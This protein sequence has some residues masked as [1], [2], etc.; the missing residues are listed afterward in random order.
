MNNWLGPFKTADDAI[1][2]LRRSVAEIIGADPNTWPDHKNAPLAIS[3]VVG[4]RAGAIKQLRKERDDVAQQLVQSEIGKREI[5]EAH[6]AMQIE[7]GKLKDLEV[8]RCVKINGYIVDNARLAE[9]VERLRAK[10][11]RMERQEP[12]GYGV[13]YVEA[14]N[15]EEDWD[16][17]WK[18]RVFAEDHVKD[19]VQAYSDLGESIGAIT[20]VPLYALPGAKGE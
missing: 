9:E 16:S 11:E 17:L 14:A 15:G 20:V 7:V 13:L 4:L 6:D 2:A 12:A 1:D 18:H 8:S 10:I 19:F 3:A 5:S